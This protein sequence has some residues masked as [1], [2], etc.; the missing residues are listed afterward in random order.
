[1]IPGI[2]YMIAGLVYFIVNYM[3]L[4]EKIKKGYHYY[5]DILILVLLLLSLLAWPV[6]LSLDAKKKK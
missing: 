4:E 5:G 6:L 1:M 3:K 2:A